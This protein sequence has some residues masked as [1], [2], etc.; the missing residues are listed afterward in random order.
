MQAGRGLLKTPQNQTMTKQILKRADLLE[1]LEITPATY[2]KW[3]E[4]GLLRP[5]KLKG[6]TYRY[7]KRADV[8]RALQLEIKP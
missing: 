1:W 5:I 2:R 3:L 4:S 6:C 7:F 8:V